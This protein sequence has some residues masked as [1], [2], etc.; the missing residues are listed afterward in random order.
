MERKTAKM[1]QMNR[2]AVSNRPLRGFTKLNKF[3]NEITMEV[4][5]W[6]P[7]LT[8]IFFFK[9]SQNSLI[10]VLIFLDSVPCVFCVLTRY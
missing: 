9:S 8:R 5:G 4:G 10:P 3:Q 6:G 2:D 7:G 1:D